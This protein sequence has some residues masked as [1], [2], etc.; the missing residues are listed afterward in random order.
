M[1]NVVKVVVT[2]GLVASGSVLWLGSR[3]GQQSIALSVIHDPFTTC[4]EADDDVVYDA[5]SCG[6]FDSIQCH[7]YCTGDCTVLCDAACT[8][9]GGAICSFETMGNLTAICREWALCGDDSTPETLRTAK[10]LPSVP[11]QPGDITPCP[12]SVTGGMCDHHAL[13]TYCRPNAE[14]RALV[15]AG[16]IQSAGD[17]MMLLTN[18]VTTCR[19]YGCNPTAI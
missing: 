10:K 3:R 9:A 14:C 11:P 18:L 17:A 16:A 2:A 1:R 5:A 13:C 8:E 19:D 6:E 15:H 4:S 7:N 12:T